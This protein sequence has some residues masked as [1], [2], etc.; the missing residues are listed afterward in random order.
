MTD[1]YVIAQ[2]KIW[3]PEMSQKLSHATNSTFFEVNSESELSLENLG[4][5]A[6][7][8]IFFPHWSSKIGKD[9]FENFE[10]IV[11]HMTDLPFG[12]GGSPLQNL[13]IRGHSTTRISALRCQTEIDAGPIYLK[14]KLSLVGSAQEIYV[15]AASVIREMIIEIIRERPLPVDQIGEATYFKR[16][17]P[18]ESE[19]NC[20]GSLTAVYDMIRMLDAD[21]YPHAFIK[22]DNFRLELR[23]ARW[24]DGVLHA[25]SRLIADETKK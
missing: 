4:K 12:R 24:I 5:L 6:P 7:R 25:D 20:V 14:K 13:I 8:I 10:C 21:G 3:D 18:D 9:I 1:S 2:S 15:R 23:N 11:F 16:R 19:I 17:K 22:M